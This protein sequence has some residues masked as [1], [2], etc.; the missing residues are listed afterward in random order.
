MNIGLA[1]HAIG[2]DRD[3]SDSILSGLAELPADQQNSEWANEYRRIIENATGQADGQSA[4]Q[5]E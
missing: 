3:A 2:G 4:S 5:P 1:Q